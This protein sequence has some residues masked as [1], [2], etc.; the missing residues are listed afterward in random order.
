MVGKVGRGEAPNVLSFFSTHRSNIPLFHY[1]SIFHH[2]NIP[3]IHW[4]LF[5]PVFQWG[6]SSC[7]YDEALVSPI[8]GASMG[9][10]EENYHPA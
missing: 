2:S 4:P 5:Q 8:V 9:S 3:S 6:C 1:S 7:G 10:P